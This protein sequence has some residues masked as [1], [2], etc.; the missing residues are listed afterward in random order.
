MAVAGTMAGMA[1]MA[2]KMMSAK[3]PKL[4]KGPGKRAAS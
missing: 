3:M 1:D 4:G 2:T